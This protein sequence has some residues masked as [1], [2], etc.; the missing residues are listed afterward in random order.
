MSQIPPVSER[1]TMRNQNHLSSSP[2]DS[3]KSDHEHFSVELRK[4]KRRIL[5]N[6]KRSLGG[7][8]IK[9]IY[10]SSSLKSLI[11]TFTDTESFI[12]NILDLLYKGNS[13]NIIECFSILD[14]LVKSEELANTILK[15]NYMQMLKYY[16]SL[17]DIPLLRLTT[18]LFTNLACGDSENINVLIENQVIQ[19]LTYLS[20]SYEADIQRNALWA[21]CNMCK[22]SDSLRIMLVE[23]GVDKEIIEKALLRKPIQEK[24]FELLT[25]LCKFA[26]YGEVSQNYLKIVYC[27]VRQ[28]STEYP[29]EV[30]ISAYWILFYLIYFFPLNIDEMLKYR[31]LLPTIVQVVI[32]ENHLELI[33]AASFNLSNVSGSNATHTQRLLDSNGLEAVERLIGTRYNEL[34]KEGYFILSNITAGVAEQIKAVVT[35]KNLIIDCF[36]GLYDP[37]TKVRANALIMFLNI[38]MFRCK[39]FIL[40]IAKKGLICAIAKTIQIEDDVKCTRNALALIEY[41]IS[42]AEIG[43]YNAIKE[44]LHDNS[45]FEWISELVNHRDLKV[46]T[47]SDRILRSEFEYY[48]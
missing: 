36:A 20:H 33:K 37:D 6:I 9:L 11:T 38:S 5:S 34:K 25:Y 48:D 21:L 8:S 4:K 10:E 19:R 32:K 3:L 44:E 22:E 12:L 27:I 29:L 30:H 26:T 28:H 18:S 2:Q 17:D 42:A 15:S 23:F 46:S 47:I 13:I 31:D 40:N 45:I 1:L 7:E 43:D 24:H 35:Y 39:D 16:L 41:I 14:R